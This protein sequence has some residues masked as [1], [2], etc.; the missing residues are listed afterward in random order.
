MMNNPQASDQGQVVEEKATR[1]GGLR[2]KL[3]RSHMVLSVIGAGLLLVAFVSTLQMRSSTL[4]LARERGPMV[5]AS[6]LALAGVERSQAGL[7]GWMALGDPAFVEDRAQAW[8]DEIEPAI[9]V[10]ERISRE[11]E[12]SEDTALPGSA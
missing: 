4:R 2:R 10:L 8:T 5:R 12:R 1:G 6:T 9:D 7:R 3:F 11:S